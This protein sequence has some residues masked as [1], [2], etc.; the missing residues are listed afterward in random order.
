MDPTTL[1]MMSGATAPPVSITFYADNYYPLGNTST[2]LTWDVSNALSVSIDQGIGT[3]G[4]SGS[5]TQ[6][7]NNQT[8]TY[9]LS[10][11]GLDGI[12][13]SASITVVWTHV[14]T[15]VNPTTHPGLYAWYCPW[16]VG[17]PSFPE[18]N[19]ICT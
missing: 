17:D 19:E 6:T 2:T 18:C 7:Q 11:V 12:N 15:C 14:L 8:R 9:T 10:A 5:T 1:R 16:R 3:V 4:S 13:Y